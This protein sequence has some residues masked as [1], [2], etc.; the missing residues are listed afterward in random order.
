MKARIAYLVCVM[1]KNT[2]IL[3]IILLTTLFS[4]GVFGCG[5]PT[6][7]PA[8]TD[9]LA[10]EWSWNL[11]SGWQKQTVDGG[12]ALEGTG[13]SWAILEGAVPSDCDVRLQFKIVEGGVHINFRRSV[14]EAGLSRYYFGINGTELYLE[15]Q[16]GG[17]SASFASKQIE[18]DDGWHDLEI[19]ICGGLI[20]IYVDQTLLI[21]YE[22]EA[23]LDAGGVAF[24]T[25]DDSHVWIRAL[26]IAPATASEMVAPSIEE[27]TLRKEQQARLSFAP[28]ETHEGDLILDGSEELIIENQSYLQLGN[29][30]LNGNSKLVIR[31]STFMLGR[32]DVPTVHVYINVAERAELII[33]RSTVIEQSLPGAGELIV[34]RNNGVT[35]IEDCVAEIHLIEQ[36]AGQVEIAGTEMINEIGGLLQVAGGKTHVS[37]STLGALGMIVPSGA[38]ADLTGIRSGAYLEQWDV[39]DW[40]LG[41]NYELTLEKTELLKDTL[42][43]G[44]YERGWLFFPAPGSRVRLSDS[45]LRKVFIEVDGETATFENLRIGVPSSLRYKD[46]VLENITAMGQWPFTIQDADVTIRNSDYLF[47]Q[48][49][50]TSTVTLVNSHVVEFIP[51]DFYGEMIYENCTWTNAG[52]IIGGEEYHSSGNDFVMRGSLKIAPELREHLQWKDARVTR[53]YTAVISD[54][55]GKPIPGLTVTIDGKRYTT[56]VNGEIVF[57][58]ILDETNYDQPTQLIVEK[59]G[60]VL[61]EQE[62][63]FFSETPIIIT[64]RE[65]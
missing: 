51:R 24:E 23:P 61:L 58:L 50:G 35:K 32:G 36:Y 48:P 25:L 7:P 39:R 14:S 6:E 33:E 20:N 9:A 59:L 30:Y 60:V 5:S 62:I 40:I 16:W 46:I 57:R 27:T 17:D 38:S 37:N 53:E 42:A 19:R 43:P 12:A 28:D 10:R 2:A 22:D 41:A 15:K 29:V 47:L 45:E 4:S 44:P 65:G 52:E 11:E 64:T 54:A 3:M 31:D 13:H 18:L 8:S 56:D 55:S 21:A 34:I 63:D 26:E 49:S 1:K